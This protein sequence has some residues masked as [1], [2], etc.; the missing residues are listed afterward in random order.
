[1]DDLDER[2]QICRE[3]Q[4]IVEGTVS[5]DSIMWSLFM[6]GPIERL[7]KLRNMFLNSSQEDST[8]ML[9]STVFPFTAS[10]AASLLKIC[11]LKAWF[12]KFAA[13]STSF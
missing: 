7:R 1:V 3:V 9:T 11:T 12:S 2:V 13:A 6:T 10:N 4:S 8:Y 5:I